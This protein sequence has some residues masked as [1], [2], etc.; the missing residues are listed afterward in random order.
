MSGQ[1]CSGAKRAKRD[2]AFMGLM[3]ISL[4]GNQPW[5]G[6]EARQKPGKQ[7]PKFLFCY[8]SDLSTGAEDN[9]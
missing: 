9:P 4:P 5:P 6:Y 3:D 8:E 7:A 2:W 1:T